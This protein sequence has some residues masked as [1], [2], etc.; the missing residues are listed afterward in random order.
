MA[1]NEE[2]AFT[3][4]NKWQT[5]KQDYHAVSGNRRP[6]LAS[7]T[8]SLPEIEKVR[9][10]IVSK[11]TK[12]IA[13]IKNASLGEMK[14][15]EM[16]DEIN[17]LMKQ[18]YYWEIRIRE[19]GGNVP[20]GKQ[21]YDIEGKELP[22]AP[23]YKYYGA[24][25]DLPGIKELFL[26]QEEGKEDGDD[27]TTG[28]PKKKR[29]LRKDI[30]ASIT[31]D[32]FGTTRSISKRIPNPFIDTG[33]E[34]NGYEQQIQLEAEIDIE[35]YKLLQQDLIDQE[36]WMKK[37]YEKHP[38]ALEDNYHDDEEELEQLA[39]L[40]KI[41]EQVVEYMRREAAGLTTEN[42]LASSSFKV[43]VVMPTQISKSKD[44]ITA[45]PSE[46]MDDVKEKDRDNVDTAKQ[47]LLAKFNLF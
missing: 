44:E 42:P 10:D 9:R 38:E 3:L 32:Y 29:R 27:G 1:R 24:A 33:D 41:S 18:K 8:E 35:E 40:S 46:K 23:G 20:I 45:L 11:I 4:F 21:F 36:E 43:D 26:E 30:Y 37:Y 7:H 6:L 13:A 17:K 2:K 5:F 12:N 47:S 28:G 34:D 19:L 22:G 14:I 15:R 39:N 25:K 31:P 16:N